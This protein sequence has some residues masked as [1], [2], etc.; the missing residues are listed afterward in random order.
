MRS[1][2]SS[3]WF[4]STSSSVLAVS[5]VC[6]GHTTHR[7]RRRR[8]VRVSHTHKGRACRKSQ[9]NRDAEGRH[10]AEMH[11]A[12]GSRPAH[13]PPYPTR[14]AVPPAH[15]FLAHRRKPVPRC[16][17]RFLRAN[18]KKYLQRDFFAHHVRCS[19]FDAARSATT[20]PANTAH[21][22]TRAGDA[23]GSCIPDEA[24]HAKGGCRDA[25]TKATSTA[26]TR[27]THTRLVTVSACV[28]R[29]CALESTSC[30]P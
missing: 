25:S 9:E 20:P 1:P 13:T 23:R 21:P 8:S 6:C 24:V 16:Q 10:R 3:Y 29:S 7:R 15:L 30:Q 26:V 12:G 22:I 17:G 27:G 19:S 18:V 4:R 2:R 11:R 28:G 14:A 5:V